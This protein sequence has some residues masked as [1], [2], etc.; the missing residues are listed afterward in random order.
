MSG[1]LSSL[2]FGGSKPIRTVT[3]TSGTG[4]FTPL[5]ANSICRIVLQGAGAGGSGYNASSA[6]PGTSGARLDV[7]MRVTGPQSYSIGAKGLGGIAGATT[8]PT[9]GGDTTFGTLIAPGGIA[10]VNTAQ[11]GPAKGRGGVYTAGEDRPGAIDRGGN[12]LYG[13]GGAANGGS[14]AATSYGAGGGS[15]NNAQGGDGAGGVLTIEE[16]GA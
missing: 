12:S 2:G 5:M 11:D 6:T 10:R 7:T 4:T 16:F 9:N 15:A 8:A 13:P 1:N 3:I 14:A